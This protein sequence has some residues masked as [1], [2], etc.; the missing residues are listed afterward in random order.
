VPRISVFDVVPTYRPVFDPLS[1]RGGG[2]VSMMCWCAIG[3]EDDNE[4]KWEALRTIWLASCQN[5]ISSSQHECYAHDES[6]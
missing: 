4:R 5:G 3:E 2:C 6:C 1:A